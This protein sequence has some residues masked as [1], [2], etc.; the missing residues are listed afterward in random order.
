M[1]LF[2]FCLNKSIEEISGRFI[3]LKMFYRGPIGSKSILT[4]PTIINSG[5]KLSLKELIK[6]LRIN[7]Q[8]LLPRKN[9]KET[10]YKYNVETDEF[11]CTITTE[12]MSKCLDF[13]DEKTKKILSIILN[14]N[15]RNLPISF[16]EE[17]FKKNIDFLFECLSK[18][19]LNDE[20]KI[21]LISKIISKNNTLFYDDAL[22]RICINYNYLIVE[23]VINENELQKLYFDSSKKF[24]KSFTS[25]DEKEKRNTIVEM[26]SDYFISNNDFPILIKTLIEDDTEELKLELRDRLVYVSTMG[27]LDST[28]PQDLKKCKK[29]AVSR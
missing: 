1:D 12:L 25:M 26:L 6:Q 17:Y 15:I 3:S 23:R 24:S 2:P 19:T 28:N 18:T 14:F 16:L 5:I 7:K 4:L 10:F 21:G 9:I 29:N 20:Q 22:K 27:L 11:F 8:S 13:K